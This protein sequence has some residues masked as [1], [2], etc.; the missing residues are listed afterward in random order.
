M[1]AFH[2]L[3]LSAPFGRVNRVIVASA[4]V[5][6]LVIAA[7]PGSGVVSARV[8]HASCSGGSLTV[9]VDS[10]RKPAADAYKASH[11]KVCT[12]IV[13]WDGDSNGATEGQT[14]VEK[15]NEA[16]S[17]WPN[18]MFSEQVNDP[19]WMAKAPWNYAVNLKGLIKSSVLKYW[20]MTSLAQCTVGGKLICLQD[21]LAPEVL[22]VNTHLMKKFGYKVPRTWQQWAAIGKSVAKH[23]KGYIVGTLGDSYGGW[24]YYWANQCPLE[25]FVKG[26]TLEINPKNAH[27]TEMTKLLQP[28]VKD[29]SVVDSSVFDT[30]FPTHWG[31]PDKVLM[32]P[33]ADWYALSILQDTI[34]IP[35]GQITAKDPLAWGSSKTVTTGQIGGGPWIV[36]RHD[37]GKQLKLDA[38][39]VEWETTKFNPL[40][41]SN[42]NSRP[43]LPADSKIAKPWLASLNKDK[44]FSAPPGPAIQKAVGEVWSGWS[45][46]TYSD[47]PFWSTDVKGGLAQHKSLGSS[48][49]AYAKDLVNAAKEA[50]YSVKG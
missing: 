18:V 35:A 13:T 25:H 34:G 31:K 40:P 46:V 19:I 16:G 42:P 38:S 44:Y 12:N 33:G 29:G 21:N 10:V 30:D 20:S 36:S 1:K 9:W 3:A 15:W 2:K 32:L 26:G 37:K 14:D 47:Q 41:L 50:G 24:L 45:I 5:A 17:G 49:S 7:G 6:L 4:A 39:F 27:C 11:P 28:L 23:H 48:F 43:G 8:T 22:W